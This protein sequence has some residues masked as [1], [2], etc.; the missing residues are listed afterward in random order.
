[1]Y[2]Y[3]VRLHG[4]FTRAENERRIKRAS[5]C[6]NIQIIGYYTLNQTSLHY[7]VGKFNV[8]RGSNLWRSARHMK[9]ATLQPTEPRALCLKTLY[10]CIVYLFLFTTV[11]GDPKQ[12][13]V[14]LVYLL[15]QLNLILYS[16][17]I[18]RLKRLKI[19]W[20]LWNDW[21]AKPQWA[22]QY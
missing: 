1:M 8:G 15:F 6:G 5:S 12:M 10:I 18:L 21:I 2:P 20:L 16:P 14:K 3:S 13:Y 7:I 17:R 4:L 9:E 11:L 22:V 19:D